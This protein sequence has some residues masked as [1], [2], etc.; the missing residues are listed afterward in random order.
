MIDEKE[1][2]A[3][4]ASV[5]AVSTAALGAAGFSVAASALP[6]PNL[7][8]IEL[9]KPMVILLYGFIESISTLKTTI[10][11]LSSATL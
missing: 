11:L 2:T 10:H 9:K 4:A 5:G 8:R 3:L 7:L 1:K 6:I